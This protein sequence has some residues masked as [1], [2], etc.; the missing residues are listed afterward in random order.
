MLR[1]RVRMNESRLAS[2]FE[3]VQVSVR[4]M[5]PVL[6]HAYIILPMSV[7][8]SVHETLNAHSNMDAIFAA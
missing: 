1:V 4:I 6:F 5:H 7:S 2:G 8:K 3:R